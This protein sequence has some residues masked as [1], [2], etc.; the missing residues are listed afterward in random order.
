MFLIDNNVQ[1]HRWCSQDKMSN[2]GHTNRT[3]PS[4]GL[5]DDAQTS[6]A[7]PSIWNNCYR[8]RP[9][10]PPKLKY[11]EEFCLCENHREC[12][13]FLSEQ[14]APLPGHIRSPRSH[15][16]RTKS[17]FGRIVFFVLL[18]LLFKF[19]PS[20]YLSCLSYLFFSF[21]S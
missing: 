8:S 19:L 13:L 17:S 5:M 21:L 11:Q 16:K 7:F 18:I 2:A 15:A 6:L 9:I 4:L 14:T 12:P 20:L 3:C 1:I 10:A